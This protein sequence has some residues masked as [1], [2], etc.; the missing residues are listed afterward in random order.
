MRPDFSEMFIGNSFFSH[1]YRAALFCIPAFFLLRSIVFVLPEASDQVR[2][3]PNYQMSLLLCL[4]SSLPFAFSPKIAHSLAGKGKARFHSLIIYALATMLFLSCAY[5]LFQQSLFISRSEDLLKIHQGMTRVS[6]QNDEWLTI[7]A[8]S[9]GTARKGFGLKLNIVGN[10][11][12]Q[13]LKF[14]S[15]AFANSNEYPAFEEKLSSVLNRK[16]VHSEGLK[17]HWLSVD[18][19]PGI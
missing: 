13:R 11:K 18:S 8:E 2:L 17:T 6:I 12:D 16:A 1:I 15:P 14:Y 10:E 9:R 5:L 7:R 19:E 4:F 3:F